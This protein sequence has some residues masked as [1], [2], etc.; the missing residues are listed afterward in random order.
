M[1]GGGGNFPNTVV[2]VSSI[3]GC[4]EEG[5]KEFQYAL[6][7]EEDGAYS[8]YGQCQSER[9]VARECIRAG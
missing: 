9:Y 1:L 6:T 4:K 2:V 8:T 7:L 5:L 3:N